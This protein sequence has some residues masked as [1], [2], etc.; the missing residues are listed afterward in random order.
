MDLDRRWDQHWRRSELD[1]H[2]LGGTYEI[3]GDM[4][5]GFHMGSDISF[6]DGDFVKDRAAETV[7]L[8]GQTTSLHGIFPQLIFISRFRMSFNVIPVVAM[9]F[10]K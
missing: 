5:T 7:P 4:V 8:S 6:L 9:F 1:I 3:E 10:D 2:Y